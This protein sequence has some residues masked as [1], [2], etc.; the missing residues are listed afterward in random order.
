MRG[1]SLVFAAA[2]AV[3][4]LTTAVPARA[5]GYDWR[6]RRQEWREHEWR[7]HEWREQQWR[8]QNWNPPA[9]YA[10][11]PVYYAPPPYGPRPYYAPPGLYSGPPAALMYR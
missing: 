9:Y 10:P 6:W 2:G 1:L 4:V 11:P 7:E 5:D 3:S 8:R